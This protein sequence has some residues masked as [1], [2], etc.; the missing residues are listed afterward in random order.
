MGARSYALPASD[1]RP[2]P[3]AG[4]RATLPGR[5]HVEDGRARVSRDAQEARS[6][7]QHL[8]DATARRGARR[9]RRPDPGHAQ[10]AHPPEPGGVRRGGGPVRSRCRRGRAVSAPWR[11]SRS[12]TA[13]IARTG[14]SRASSS[15][16]R[17]R[18]TC[19]ISLPT[20]LKAVLL[21]GALAVRAW[22][23]GGVG[24]DG[25]VWAAGDDRFLLAGVAGVII[26][27]SAISLTNFV[28][29]PELSGRETTVD[30]FYESADPTRPAGLVA[31]LAVAGRDVPALAQ[32]LSEPYLALGARGP[33]GRL[34]L[35]LRRP[36][37]AVSRARLAGARGE[38]RARKLMVRASASG[39]AHLDRPRARAPP[40]APSAGSAAPVARAGAPHPR[41]R[42]RPPSR[43]RPRPRSTPKGPRPGE[44]RRAT[45]AR[46]EADPRLLPHLATLRDHFGAAKGPFEVQQRRARGRAHRGSRLARRRGRS[47][48]ACDRP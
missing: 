41:L 15:S 48:R 39:R 12:A 29:R 4:I 35:A 13:S 30:A 10:S 34:S 20:K 16:R 38:V 11:S 32:P 37:R 46:L 21:A 19:S 31:R 25:H 27:A 8:P 5:S 43:P 33:D 7:L 26:V 36:Q 18:V 44:A 6:A 9:R 1:R 42:P 23:A 24:A 47:H 22:R 45:F 14:C 17:R 3:S 40:A 2:R 28:R